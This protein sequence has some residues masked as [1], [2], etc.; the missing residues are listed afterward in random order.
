MRIIF[1]KIKSKQAPFRDSLQNHRWA[2]CAS[3]QSLLPEFLKLFITNRPRGRSV[4]F[5]ETLSGFVQVYLGGYILKHVLP[6]YH[7][8]PPVMLHYV[9]LGR[10]RIK[11]RRHPDMIIAAA[12]GVK[13]QIKP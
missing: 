10:S 4:P 12:W 1:T 9:M 2:A 3:R 11:W 13:Q 7:V 5:Q 8:I 6:A